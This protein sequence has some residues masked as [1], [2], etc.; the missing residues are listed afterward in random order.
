MEIAY[1]IYAS[2]LNVKLKEEAEEKLQEMQFG[3]REERRIMDVVYVM[4]HIIN[5][6][7][8]KKGGKVFAFFADLKAA[9]DKVDRKWLNEM[10]KSM[11][12]SNHLK[13]QVMET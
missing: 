11:R 1:K 9:F 6:E 2:I 8:K 10:I 12:I 5:K 7:L 3:F 13:R 4:N